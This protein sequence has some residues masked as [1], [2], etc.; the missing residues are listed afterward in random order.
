MH[1][2]LPVVVN[3]KSDEAAAH[4]AMSGREQ[5]ETPAVKVPRLGGRVIVGHEDEDEDEMLVLLRWPFIEHPSRR[6]LA[7]VKGLL[8]R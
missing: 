4:R 8:L 2:K 1:S 3:V 6:A 5:V 7:I